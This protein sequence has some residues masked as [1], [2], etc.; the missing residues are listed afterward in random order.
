[1]FVQMQHLKASAPYCSRVR[2]RHQLGC[3]RIESQRCLRY[4]CILALCVEAVAVFPCCKHG[5]GRHAGSMGFMRHPSTFC[6]T[7]SESASTLAASCIARTVLHERNDRRL[8][9]CGGSRPLRRAAPPHPLC[10][11]AALRLSLTVRSQAIDR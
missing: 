10:C 3:G 7:S 9:Y 2:A 6:P 4:N 11:P 5:F 1:M 8:H